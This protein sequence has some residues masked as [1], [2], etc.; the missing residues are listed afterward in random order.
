MKKQKKELNEYQ[1]NTI[2]IAL[3]RYIQNTYGEEPYYNC[4]DLEDVC[5]IESII[6]LLKGN[7]WITR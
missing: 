7:K 2:C 1:I 5:Y 6:D 4:D 3:E